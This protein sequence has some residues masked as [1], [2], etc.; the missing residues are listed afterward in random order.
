MY[1]IYCHHSFILKIKAGEHM[2]YCGSCD[3][4]FKKLKSSLD[5]HEAE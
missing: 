2:K 1:Y 3:Q 5:E 4:K